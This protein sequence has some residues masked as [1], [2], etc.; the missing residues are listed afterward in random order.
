MNIDMRFKLNKVL[1]KN[2]ALEFL[3][4][5]IAGVDFS[6]G[7]IGPHLK[8]KGVKN[9]T[10]IERKAIINDYF[11]NFYNRYRKE[12][13]EKVEVFRKDWLCVKDKFTE[14]VDKIFKN[15]ELPKGKYIAYLSI[16]NCNPRF[17]DE[18]TFQIFFKHKA[19]SNYIAMHELLHF[20]FYDYAD[21]NYSKIFSKL[22]KNNGIYWDLAEI[23]NAVILDLPE[24]ITIHKN[25]NNNPY[26]AHKKHIKFMRRL[27][28]DNLDIDIWISEAYKYLKNEQT[29]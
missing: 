4:I 13:L 22:D 23:F 29:N 6:Q 16:I 1:D 24:F 8:L 26:L 15:P 14:Q 5:D 9:K 3:N 19:G 12:L 17:L 7:V 21:K 11:D 28:E 25:T 10:K 27:W 2:M 20:F 18:K